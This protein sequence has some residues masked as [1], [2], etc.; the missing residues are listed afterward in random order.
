MS[1]DNNDHIEEALDGIRKQIDEL[2]NFFRKILQDE[3]RYSQSDMDRLAELVTTVSDSVEIL[4]NYNGEYDRFAR[5]CWGDHPGCYEVQCR[6]CKVQRLCAEETTRRNLCRGDMPNCFRRNPLMSHRHC[7][8]CS[9]FRLCLEE[10][11]KKEIEVP[12]VSHADDVTVV[13]DGK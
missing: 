13:Y 6:L 1:I 7:W 3:L 5:R 2:Q 12:K 10:S 4:K 11:R 9:L 8:G